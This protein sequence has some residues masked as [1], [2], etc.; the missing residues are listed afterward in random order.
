LVLSHKSRHDLVMATT[1]IINQNFFSGSNWFRRTDENVVSYVDKLSVAKGLV[2][3]GVAE[4]SQDPT[5][6]IPSKRARLCR[7]GIIIDM[8]ITIVF[9]VPAFALHQVFRLN[10]TGS[11]K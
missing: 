1:R 9:D 7:G 3:F 4:S 2:G 8:N 5:S 10:V 6:N 11:R